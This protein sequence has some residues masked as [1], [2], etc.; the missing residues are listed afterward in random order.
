MEYSLA[1]NDFLTFVR[2]SGCYHGEMS[3][4]RERATVSFQVLIITCV[5]GFRE[6]IMTVLMCENSL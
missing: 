2:E 1:N 5:Q 3:N 6:R 4:E